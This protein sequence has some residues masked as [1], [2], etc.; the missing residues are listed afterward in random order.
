[1]FLPI[2]TAEERSRIW[3]EPHGTKYLMDLHGIPYNWI[4]IVRQLRPLPWKFFGLLINLLFDA[5]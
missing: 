5:I 1:M 4:G 3:E 2:I